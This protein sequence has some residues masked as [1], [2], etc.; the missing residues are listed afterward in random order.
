MKEKKIE[1]VFEDVKKAEEEV[2][3]TIEFIN[4]IPENL[5]YNVVDFAENIISAP[6]VS[7]GDA[8]KTFRVVNNNLIKSPNYVVEDIRDIPG[9]LSSFLAKAPSE[10]REDLREYLVYKKKIRPLNLAD[11]VVDIIDT[12]LPG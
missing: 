9:L 6:L 5:Y 12:I 3:K 10:V 8:A 2:E 7:F 11:I 4:S 1:K